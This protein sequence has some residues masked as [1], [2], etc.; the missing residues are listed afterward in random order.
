MSEV[1][2]MR[3]SYRWLW[4]IPV[5]AVIGAPAAGADLSLIDAVKKSDS[6]G[7]RTLLD[8]HGDPNAAEPDGTTAL[9]WAVTRDDLEMAD[10]LIQA[11]ARVKAANRYGVTPLTIACINGNR[12]M[13]AMLLNAGADPKTALPEGE[14]ALM[15]AARTGNAEVVKL[16]LD[17]G[18][19]VGAKEGWH[20]QSALMWAAAENH[21]A[22]VAVLIDAHA[23]IHARSNGG[24]TPLLLAVRAGHEGMVHQLVAAG[25]NVDDT[26]K[27]GTSALH[28][29]LINARY[30]L[31]VWL[32][33]HGANANANRPG[34]TP[35]HQLEWTR[36]PN[37]G[38]L[39]PAVP[40]GRMETMDVARALVKHGANLNARQSKE[41]SD[42]HRHMR[43]RLG[44]T[45]FFLA[46]K[47]ADVEMMKFLVDNGADP[48]VGTDEHTT[49]L[50]AAAGVG[51]WQLGENPG[52]ND[53]AVEA[54]KLC[55]DLGG[56]VN[57]VDDQ[58]DTAMHG[59]VHRG[60]ANQVVQFLFDHGAKLDVRNKQGWTPLI[61][62]E[63]VHYPNTFNRFPETAALLRRLGARDTAAQ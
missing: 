20:G 8:R 44:A 23:D 62:A 24:F 56:D 4:A 57:A 19:D 47:A 42:G 18:A 7:V 50:M 58:G 27:D 12:A 54:V 3:A 52:T 37:E 31:A 48:A 33:D 26:V 36:R 9:H 30:E 38:R 53:E 46:A 21:S 59:A 16:L 60:G 61:I 28:L 22:A 6:A 49:P 35:F 34:W 15:T 41:P 14:T 39:I 51:I 5:L 29:A 45:P 2:T 43:N 32:L 13:V 63:G 40:T 55:L 11:G 17:R 25:A 10:R 1:A